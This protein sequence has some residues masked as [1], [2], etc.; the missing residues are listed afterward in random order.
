MD[1][2]KT[3]FI[4]LVIAYAMVGE[5]A[6]P[7]GK[8]RSKTMREPAFEEL[9]HTFESDALW[10][11][12]QMDMVG[13]DHKSVQ[14]I[15]FAVM[16]KSVEKELR[17]ALDLEKTAAIRA[18]GGDEVRSRLRGTAGNRHVANCICLWSV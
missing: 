9:H 10:S 15:V 5:T 18:G 11:E 17:V 16:N 2:A 1:I 13:H 4:V 12:E 7:Y 3:R 14:Q 8:F 6:L